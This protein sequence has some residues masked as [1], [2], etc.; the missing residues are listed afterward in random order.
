MDA[1]DGGR[2][3]EVTFGGWKNGMVIY[4]QSIAT[5]TEP[6]YQMEAFLSGIPGGRY[7]VVEIPKDFHAKLQLALVESDWDKRMEMFKELHKMI[8]DDYCMAVPVYTGVTLAAAD[9]KKVHN[10]DIDAVD[11]AF[12]HPEKVWLS[13]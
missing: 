4:N 2:W 9:P 3:V 10:F 11:C 7:P 12:W 8:I 6:G 1:V 13:K 5:R